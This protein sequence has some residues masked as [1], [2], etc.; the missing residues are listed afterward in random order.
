MI[1]QELIGRFLRNECNAEE[2]AIIEEHFAA[3]PDDLDRYFPEEDC[4][5]GVFQEALPPGVSAAWLQK[6]HEKMRPRRRIIPM[7]RWSAAAAAIIAIAGT[8]WYWL[9][10][11]SP[12]NGSVA[13][14]LE[15]IETPREGTRYSNTS[16]TVQMIRLPDNSIAELEPA[17]ILW[18]NGAYITGDRRSVYVQGEARFRVTRDDLHPFIVN[19][20]DIATTVLGT[21]FKVR[22]VAGEDYISVRL[23][24]GKVRVTLVRSAKMPLT[25]GKNL[26]PGDELLYS[27]STMAMNIRSFMKRNV[28][29]KA[30][31][32]AGRSVATG[33]RPN[34]Y[35]FQEQ[36]LEE[37][38]DQLSVYYRADI[39]YHPADMGNRYFTGKFDQNDS[40]ANILHAIGLLNHFDII[41][42]D[43]SFIIKKSQ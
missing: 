38:L 29:V 11:N 43:Q 24:T 3:H 33:A 21:S 17:A 8:G 19:S 35:M 10:E 28:L 36:S 6:V 40:L 15:V 4:R 37:V 14:R 25:G 22:D 39:Y 31:K 42:E 12:Q 32:G 9:R 1:N 34:W 2:K 30:G 41:K 18:Y 23:Y 26:S 7:L 20:D 27:R 13:G 5:D 16:D